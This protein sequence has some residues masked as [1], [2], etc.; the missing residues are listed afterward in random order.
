MTVEPD[1]RRRRPSHLA[2]DPR[3][4][5]EHDDDHY[6]KSERDRLARDPLP[7]ERGGNRQGHEGLEQL[8][9]VVSEGAGFGSRWGDHANGLAVA[10]QRN[11]ETTAPA[12][13]PRQIA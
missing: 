13:L 3:L 5:S 9:I 2:R 8:D 4:A 1:R 12:A 7:E 10:Q 11:T 6:G